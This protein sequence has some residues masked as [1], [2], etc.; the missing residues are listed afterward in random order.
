MLFTYEIRTSNCR[1]ELVSRA[2]KK[3]KD[4]ETSSLLQGSLSL[5]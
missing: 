2:F 4:R 3:S 5:M 1:S